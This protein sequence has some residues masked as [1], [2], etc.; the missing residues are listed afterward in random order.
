MA[1]TS[2]IFY[3]CHSLVPPPLPPPSLL[4][5]S[6]RLNSSEQNNNEK[7]TCC[8]SSIAQRTSGRAET[9]MNENERRQHTYTYTRYEMR[10]KQHCPSE[11][12]WI[13]SANDNVKP[14]VCVCVW[15]WYRDRDDTPVAVGHPESEC[16]ELITTGGEP[17][18][19]NDRECVAHT[20]TTVIN[21]CVGKLLQTTKCSLI[22][23]GQLNDNW[24]MRNQTKWHTSVLHLTQTTAPLI[25]KCVAVVVVTIIMP[26]FVSGVLRPIRAH[27][28]CHLTE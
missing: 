13:T 5:S 17:E 24:H 2:R 26:V 22:K 3:R 6:P 1:F 27:F 23:F 4:H 10:I 28:N 14:S 20:E 16:V 19:V 12:Q 11:R 7:N 21:S 15:R 25:P 18:K 9:L 8:H